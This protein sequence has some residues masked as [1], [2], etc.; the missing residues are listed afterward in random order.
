M[1]KILFTGGHHTPAVSVIAQIRKQNLQVELLWVGHKYSMVNDVSQSAEY[2]EISLL[3]I[4][5]IELK[6]TKVYR[7][8]NISSI[9][10]FITS[11]YFAYLII[12][13]E[14]PDLVVSFGGYLAVPIVIIAKL[15][16]SIRVISHEQTRASGFANRVI[17][18]FAD[19]I[20]LTWPSSAKFYK[21]FI[22][23]TSIVGLPVRQDI[24]QGERLDL[25]N[26]DLLTIYITG[27]KQ[28]SHTINLVIESSLEYLLANFNV[29][30]QVGSNSYYKDFERMK[31]LG[32][33]GKGKYMIEQFVGQDKIG[34]V[35]QS[36][37]IVITR[38]GANTIYELGLLGKP[39]I[40]IPI[41]K[42][43]HNEQFENA[44]FLEENR[45]AIIITEKEFTKQTLIKS[46][47][48]IKNQLSVYKENA[49]KANTKLTKNAD[50]S[51]TEKISYWLSKTS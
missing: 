14:R 31:D 17:A 47:E 4:K 7:N 24:F 23:K 32:K 12:K 48:S 13:N 1:K 27:G 5:F 43:S 36:T 9:F 28:G 51:I 37:D 10:K 22:H 29:V 34:S 19:E 44:K 15:L 49:Q 42:S 41:T 8:V 18:Y 30:H 46:L 11:L 20:L 3:S 39:A 40:I 45:S 2:K 25:L 16:F 21:K 33:I 38:G 35:F 50:V 6:A 26:P